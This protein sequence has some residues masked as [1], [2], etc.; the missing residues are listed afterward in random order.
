MMVFR[1]RNEG[2]FSAVKVLLT[3]EV[4]D[5]IIYKFLSS[6]KKRKG[7]EWTSILWFKWF[8]VLS[9]ETRWKIISREQYIIIY[10]TSAKNKNN[11]FSAWI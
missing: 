6:L 11:I 10:L 3:A 1:E 2:Q 4:W 8:P 7:A 9:H 5:E